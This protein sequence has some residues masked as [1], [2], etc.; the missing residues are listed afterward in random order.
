MAKTNGILATSQSISDIHQA[1]PI[2]SSS[3]AYAFGREFQLKQLVSPQLVVL[4]Q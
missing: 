1:K 3:D 4:Y 2:D